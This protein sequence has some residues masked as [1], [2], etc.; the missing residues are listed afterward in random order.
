MPLSYKCNNIFFSSQVKSA[1][2]KV[3]FCFLCPQSVEPAEDP[4]FPPPPPLGTNPANP[5]EMFSDVFDAAF[6]GAEGSAQLE[7]MLKAFLDP[8]TLKNIEKIAEAAGSTG[9]SYLDV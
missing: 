3:T 2:V 6:S 7:D 9:W 8:D 5:D 1:K 4:E